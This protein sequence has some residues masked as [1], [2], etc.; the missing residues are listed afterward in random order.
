[1]RAEKQLLLDEIKNK[2]EGSS[3][4]LVTRYQKLSANAAN[5]LRREI[6][7]S[8]GDFEVVSK[9]TFLKAAEA[10]GVTL[11]PELLEG[12]IGVVF[13]GDDGV[14]TAKAVFTFGQ[15]NENTVEVLSARFDGKM[16]GREDVEKISKLPDIQTM[17]AQFLGIL[18]AP[19]AQTLGV[20]EALL[21]AIPCC[22]EQKAKKSG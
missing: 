22:L 9:R 7:K 10:A 21:T 18:A 14:T 2:L 12:H 3:T 8:G 15:K 6:R 5:G 20:I 19:M 17:R 4:F 16:Y 13:A 11:D 1:M